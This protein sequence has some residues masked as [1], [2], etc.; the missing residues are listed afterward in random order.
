MRGGPAALYSAQGMP[1]KGSKPFVGIVSQVANT[2]SCVLSLY[3]VFR[4]PV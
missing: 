1:A 4:Q 3:A 2:R